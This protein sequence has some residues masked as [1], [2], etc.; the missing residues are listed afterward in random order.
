MIEKVSDLNI[1]QKLLEVRK[2]VIVP[3]TQK[4][5]FGNYNY[6]SAEQILAVANDAAAKYGCLILLTD[7]IVLIGTRY[8]NYSKAIFIDTA[9]GQK[10]ETTA[11]ARE[12]ETKTGMDLSQITGSTMSYSRKYA[13]GG[14]LGIDDGKDADSMDNR[15]EGKEKPKAKAKPKA[16]PKAEPEDE[17]F[18]TPVENAI[19][20]LN[21]C[22]E[23]SEVRKVWD[24]YP[25]LQ[26]NETFK[27]SCRQRVKKLD[28]A[29][30]A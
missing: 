13:L 22:L 4:N 29:N 14:L 16:A 1:Y 8:Y 6:R 18:T 7:D 12:S 3:K 10:I 25:Q 11:P 19:A 28:E 17:E 21:L 20:E 5:N 26:K 2:E 27:E 24:K 15:E 23:K 30:A 9:D